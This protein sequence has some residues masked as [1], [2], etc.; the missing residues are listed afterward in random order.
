MTVPQEEYVR[1]VEEVKNLRQLA[2]GCEEAK[3]M[4]AKT[5]EELLSTRI[6]LNKATYQLK[7]QQE[8]EESRKPTWEGL[9]HSPPDDPSEEGQHEEE[10]EK[11]SAA[12][13]PTSTNNAHDSA[14]VYASGDEDSDLDMALFMDLINE[15]EEELE[16]SNAQLE[17]LSAASQAALPDM[18]L[19][20]QLELRDAENNRLQ[21]QLASSNRVNEEI[22]DKFRQSETKN[23]QL[24]NERHTL[25]QRLVSAEETIKALQRT[26]HAVDVGCQTNLSSVQ[27]AR[28]THETSEL[29]QRAHNLE[30]QLEERMQNEQKL[31]KDIDS[32]NASH[33][34]QLRMERQN[35]EMRLQ[36]QMRLLGTESLNQPQVQRQSVQVAS[37]AETELRAMRIKMD[38][39]R[40]A[41]SSIVQDISF[42]SD[43]RVHATDPQMDVAHPVQTST[44]IPIMTTEYPQPIVSSPSPESDIISAEET[45]ITM[46]SEHSF[47]EEIE[48]IIPA[49]ELVSRKR[50]RQMENYE[51][52]QQ[53]MA[54]T[55]RLRSAKRIRSSPSKVT[56]KS[57]LLSLHFLKL[58][59]KS[60]D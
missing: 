31:L 55:R 13:A 49:S 45:L 43:D 9:T 10:E 39:I 60:T 50:A 27:I 1:V 29:Q 34:Q 28:M 38:R 19:Q 4:L 30:Q 42:E 52:E 54:S 8:Q 53:A 32:L 57:T 46:P 23:R 18:H 41:L 33:L 44:I 25:R 17:E 51:S 16:S 35:S 56:Q 59:M 58:V 37:D 22:T 6:N 40:T 20:R 36:E 47:S 3:S 5:K 21:E 7:M 48:E 14:H 24:E 15:G 11:N 2:A 26:S 12:V